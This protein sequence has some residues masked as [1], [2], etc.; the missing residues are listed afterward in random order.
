MIQID[1]RERMKVP[2]LFGLSLYSAPYQVNSAPGSKTTKKQSEAESQA[3]T[4]KKRKW[5]K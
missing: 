3:K 1:H 2:L 5:S 4:K